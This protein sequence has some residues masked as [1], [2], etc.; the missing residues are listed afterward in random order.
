LVLITLAVVVFTVRHLRNRTPLQ[1]Q[2][3]DEQAESRSSMRRR[4][5]RSEPGSSG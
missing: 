2:K 5:R 4:R 1:E 3:A